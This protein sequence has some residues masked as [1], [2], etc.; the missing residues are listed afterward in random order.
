VSAAL[1][2]FDFD[3]T[4]TSTDT[5]TPF[6]KA[7]LSTWRL[8]ASRVLLTPVAVG[9]RLGAISAS[10]GREIAA[11]VAFRGARADEIRRRGRDYA[12]M[13]LPSTLRADALDRLDW[14]VARGD[15]VMIVSAGLDVY[16]RPWC[17]ARRVAVICTTLEERAGRLTGRCVGGDCAGAEK[18]RRIQARCAPGRYGEIY[19]YGDSIEDRE[20]LELATR[21]YYRG[22]EISSWRDVAEYG[23]PVAPAG[24]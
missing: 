24:T 4:L 22:A 15:D 2:L 6:M 7:A 10:R 9:H 12:A 21:K 8:A 19:A 16:L 3:G 18:A 23:H 13:V 5:W 14:H 20:M 1:A 17:E 11:R